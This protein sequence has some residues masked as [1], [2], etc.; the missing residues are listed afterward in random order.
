MPRLLG[1]CALVLTCALLAAP[2]PAQE[3]PTKPM[4]IVVGPGPDVMA[5]LFAQKMSERWHQEGLVHPQPGGGGLVAMRTVSKAQPAGHTMLLTTG[6]YTINE[7]LRPNFPVSL[8][9]D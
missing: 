4:F 2:A 8:M 5:R 6:S 7:A 3:F 1:R 9:R